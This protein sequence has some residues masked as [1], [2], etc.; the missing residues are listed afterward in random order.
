DWGDDE[1]IHLKS[2]KYGNINSVH[3]FT[4][5]GEYVINASYRE[6]VSGRTISSWR[7]IRIVDYREE[8]VRLFNEIIEN[9][10]LI[11]I[12]IGSEM[13]PREIEQ[14]LQS[15]LEGIDETTIRRL[16]SGFEEA[17]YSTHPV[18]RDN[19]LNMYRSVSEVL[20]YGI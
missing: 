19:Y 14:I 7:K 8:M 3:V 5:K 6:D 10:E 13:T 9:L 2:D 11:D 4:G 16:I 15:R 18:T 17:N 12:P 20:G 1:I